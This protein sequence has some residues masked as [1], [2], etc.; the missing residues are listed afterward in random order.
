MTVQKKIGVTTHFSEIIELIFDGKCHTLL[1]ILK[2]F[3]IVVCGLWL[4]IVDCGFWD[5]D[6][7]SEKYVVTHNFLFGFQ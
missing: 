6:C 4:R 1:W 2:L 7:I 3:R 5:C